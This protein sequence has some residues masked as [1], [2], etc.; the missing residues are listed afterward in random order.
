[1]ALAAVPRQQAPEV[2]GALVA[3]WQ[4]RGRPRALQGDTE[5]SLR[6]ANRHPRSVGLLSRRC[7]YVG[8]AIVVI[9]AREP[10]RRGLMAR[11]THVDDQR[12]WRSQPC[13]DRPPLAAALPHVEACHHPQP[14]DATLAQRP[15]W[16]VHHADRRRR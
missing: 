6:G 15:P 3:G 16:E 7:R 4:T 5:R 1:M 9:P 2:V 11:V 12:F 8:V 13:R 14:R 10:W